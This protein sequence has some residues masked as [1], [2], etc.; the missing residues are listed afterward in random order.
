MKINTNTAALS[1]LR[2]TGD[3]VNQLSQS[4]RQMASGKRL[5][6][7]ADGPTEV[8]MTDTL[9]NQAAGLRQTKKSNEASASLL[10]VAEGNLA[11]VIRVLTEMRQIAIHSAGRNELPL[12]EPYPTSRRLEPQAV[13]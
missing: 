9:R 4:I 2:N 6:S 10:Q 11:E 12:A 3:R 5:N 7:A 8:L 1:T 13:W